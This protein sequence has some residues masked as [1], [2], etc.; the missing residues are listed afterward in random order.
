MQLSRNFDLKE[1]TRSRTAA[2]YG[3]DNT[4]AA[5][6]L[7][8]L[9]ALAVNILQP[10]RN[11]YNQI[12]NAGRDMKKNYPIHIGS[13]YRSPKVNELTPGSAKNS[14]HCNGEAADLD[15]AHDNALIF[16]IIKNEMPFDQLIWEY[17]DDDAPE[18]IHVSY[19]RN[20]EN[21]GEVLKASYDRINR[22][23]NYV[24]F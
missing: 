7:E 1:F 5:E 19:K 21:R 12:K 16:N 8:N 18:W 4:P 23:I 13:G 3:L 2:K 14:Q 11:R 10:A 6:H 15:T 24:Y 17:G 22:K 9:K 20:G